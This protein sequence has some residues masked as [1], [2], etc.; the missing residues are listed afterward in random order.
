MFSEEHISTIYDC[1]GY[2]VTVELCEDR[3][4]ITVRDANARFHPR[5]E[6]VTHYP[7]SLIEQVLNVKGPVWFTDEIAREE[8]PAPMS[9]SD[10]A[11]LSYLLPEQLENA[12]ILDFGCGAGAS[13]VAMARRFP[14]ATFVGID[15]L[16][17]LLKLA[18]AR[19]A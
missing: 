4:R 9:R 15:I 14:K 16:A 19:A 11:I 5:P 6:L 13:T 12:R 17:K 10:S 7:R 3:I 18:A 2:N 8:Q 1:D